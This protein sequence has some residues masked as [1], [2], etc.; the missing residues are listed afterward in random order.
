MEAINFF[1]ENKTLFTI[2]HVLAVVLGMGAALISD[3]LFNFY[4]IDKTLDHKEA[5]TL[6]FLSSV[7]WV[8]LVF[9]ILSGVGLFFSDPAKYLASDKFI[10]KMSIM[11]VLLANGLFLS[12]FVSP[13]FRDKGLLKLKSAR[14]LR[15]IAFVSGAISISSW[16]IVCILGM[17]KS[18]PVHFTQ[19]L[20]G[21]F[22]FIAVASLVALAV[23]KKTFN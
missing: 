5:R 14:T 6:E 18:I 17:L 13:H 15:Q 9:I 3:L 7:V 2:L 11:A 20:L 12:K 10:S 22:A 23:E 1:V 21:Y 8:S 19:F 16:F 4:T